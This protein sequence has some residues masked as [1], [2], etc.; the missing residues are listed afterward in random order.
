MTI[1]S[2]GPTGGGSNRRAASIAKYGGTPSF[3]SLG[4]GAF[5]GVR[6][7]PPAGGVSAQRAK[8]VVK[9]MFYAFVFSLPFET[10]ETVFT[11]PG[12]LS[13][14]KVIGYA[15]ILLSVLQPKLL[16]RRPPR[17]FYYLLAYLMIVGVYATQIDS[18]YLP[19]LRASVVML[20]QMFVL[21][22]M[23]YN[24]MRSEV[25]RR[26]VLYA[27]TGSCLLLAVLQ[28]TGLTAA[29]VQAGEYQ[30][31]SAMGENLNTVG[32]V[33]ALGLIGLIGLALASP[34]RRNRFLAW[35]LC[36]LLVGPLIQTGSRGALIGF[37][38]G[39]IMVI[40]QQGG[41]ATKVKGILTI[42]VALGLIAVVTLQSDVART[43]WE[44]TLYSNDKMAGR[45][46]IYDASIDM[47]AAR[48]ILG[49]G[50][51]R[52]IYE[53]GRR[54]GLVKRDTHNVYLWFLTEVG[55]LGAFPILGAFALC[56][57]HAW[58]ARRGIDGVL[59]LAL[60]ITLLVV[61]LAGSFHDRKWFWLI[62]ALAAASGSA[63]G[64]SSLRAVERHS[65]GA[66]PGG[67][68]TGGL[69]VPRRR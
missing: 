1:E 45:D 9:W 11:I 46:G 13:L 30:R 26:H 10:L 3:H 40:S 28:L 67:P 34:A 43:R 49:W 52:N 33:L 7:S 18:Y 15:F 57:R 39:L 53:L 31:V 23:S 2:L 38:I 50:P 65:R 36:L 60:L 24:L 25:I 14:P 61:N 20:I 27:F 42:C 59:P 8:A 66:S 29:E 22:W 55:I 51:V 44:Q 32:A 37:A 48:P 64:V 69:P 68:I 16:F 4:G 56:V 62:L 63:S 17:P 35:P 41:V 21:F 12:S 54:L 58:R 47:V 19:E 6:L 5:H